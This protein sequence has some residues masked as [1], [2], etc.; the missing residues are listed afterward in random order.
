MKTAAASRG[1]VR[2]GTARVV[3]LLGA[4]SARAWT[5][6]RSFAVPSALGRLAFNQVECPS[7]TKGLRGL[8][9]LGALLVCFLAC[10]PRV[11]Y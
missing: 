5:A 11:D 3:P 1:V 10:S 6:Q 2:S 8:P 7:A 9:A 4:R